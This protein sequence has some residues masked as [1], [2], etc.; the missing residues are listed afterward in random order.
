MSKTKKIWLGVL[1]FTP[2][3]MSI[4]FG[5]FTISIYS[6]LLIGIVNPS[7]NYAN[8]GEFLYSM[9]WLIVIGI[10]LSVV[11]YVVL[12]IF[13]ICI[14]KNK[15]IDETAKILYLLGIYFIYIVIPI[16]YFFIEVAGKNN[17]EEIEELY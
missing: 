14:V 10:L 9:M 1:S 15:K 3:L 11:S 2:L 7:L 4:I 8:G 16:V 6:K 5:I 12:V 17:D 13:T